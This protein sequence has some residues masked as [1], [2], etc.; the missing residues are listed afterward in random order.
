M[1]YVQMQRNGPGRSPIETVDEFE[2][3]KEAKKMLAEYQ[4]SDPS[5]YY[6]LSRRPCKEWK[7]S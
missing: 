3:L 2:T 1:I 7:E 6:Y 5:A 4:M